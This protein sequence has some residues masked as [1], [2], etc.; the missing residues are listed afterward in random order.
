MV[1][2]ENLTSFGK[3]KQSNLV[4]SIYTEIS[5]L[6]REVIE[7]S[8]K[9]FTSFFHKSLSFLKKEILDI[10][11][12]NPL[13]L[14]R[15][16]AL[17]KFLRQ[18]IYVSRNHENYLDQAAE[19]GAFF[20]LS[21][22]F[23]YE[24]IRQQVRNSYSINLSP[25]LSQNEE[26]CPTTFKEMSN[27]EINKKIVN[28]YKKKKDNSNEF[29][30]KSG[31]KWQILKSYRKLTDIFEFAPIFSNNPFIIALDFSEN[32]S[33]LELLLKHFIFTIQSIN[34]KHL[35]LESFGSLFQDLIPVMDRK[36]LGQIYTPSEIAEFM[37]HLAIQN[38][39]QTVLDPACGCGSLLIQSY[40]RLVSLNQY[41]QSNNSDSFSTTTSNLLYNLPY[42]IHEKVLHQLWGI[43]INVFPAYIS[44]LSLSFLNL[45][46]IT[47]FVGVFL[48][49]FLQ[50]GPLKTYMVKSKNLQTGA[51]IS[52]ILP[53][54]FDVIIANPPYIK[55]E[56]IP[57]KK[58]MMKQLPEFAT[59]RIQHNLIKS[60]LD[61]KK[62]VKRL[63]LELSGK[64]DYY[65]FFLWYSA[66]FLKEGGRLCFIIPN[67]WMDVKYGEKIKNFLLEN[68]QIRA[69]I[70]FDQNIFTAAQVS[71]V[72]LVADRC[73]SQKQRETTIVQFIRLQNKNAIP[74]VL[75]LV[76][77]TKDDKDFNQIKK[78][79]QENS[80]LY[81]FDNT[82]QGISRTAVLQKSLL[83]VEKWSMKYLYQSH[84]SQILLNRKLISLDNGIFCRVVG[85]IKTGANDFFFPSK[86]IL[87]HFRIPSEFLKPG[88]RSGRNLP[89]TF[90]I[91][92]SINPFISI[93]PE[94]EVND[95]SRISEYI[96]FGQDICHYPD[97]PSLH[98]KPW[99]SIPE[100]QQDSP[101]ILF[102]RHIDKSFRAYWN[103]IGAIVADGI[104]GIQVLNDEWLIFLLGVCNSTFFYWQAH[105]LGRWEGQGDLQLL[106]Y[107]LRR[108]LVPNM[109]EITIDQ[110]NQVIQ[111]MKNILQNSP[112]IDQV[113]EQQ[114]EILDRAVLNCLNL[115]AEYSLL[116]KE[117]QMMEQKRLSKGL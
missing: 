63:K 104:R 96:R 115:E 106:V 70:S 2:E 91:Q 95:E 102:L 89:S 79:A 60:N 76:N 38:P 66:Y 58:I 10:F 6:K 84:F 11:L 99:Y 114:Q 54:F 73:S 117:T 43:E 116:I 68:F 108:F 20:I 61:S 97:R 53:A 107:E 69:I 88:I 34:F 64:T 49:D 23:T 81:F 86:D 33:S 93:P 30:N 44:M 67:K 26:K 110:K 31:L 21:K 77:S 90:L 15:N 80:N 8:N 65:G 1:I 39:K 45:S 16:S 36:L 28:R 32:S 46:M 9:D 14:S 62:N 74:S 22:L 83:P 55:Q 4:G 18:E 50:L 41:Y 56:K 24:L 105:M 101:D 47:D 42:S 92:E 3:K 98:W 25:I 12:K 52:R 87:N 111:A 100:T 57:R 82:I 103:K 75:K 72:I 5:H 113:T 51:T 78:L 29:G 48:E 109:G 40:R 7:F 94:I 27:K 35:A 37:A 112:Q 19:M 13:I 71:T 85:G 17:E 59:Q